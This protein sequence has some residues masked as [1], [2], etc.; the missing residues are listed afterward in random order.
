MDLI[1]IFSI[2]TI[3]LLVAFIWLI[4]V[5]RKSC[6]L[7][8]DNRSIEHNG[9]RRISFTGVTVDRYP[10]SSG[11]QQNSPQRPIWHSYSPQTQTSQS[12]QRANYNHSIET[13]RNQVNNIS[14]ANRAQNWSSINTTPPPKISSL[15]L[16]HLSPTL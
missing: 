3:V 16:I 4:C 12:N 15:L 13:F 9:S 5:C 14:Y 10:N 1:V 8:S 7:Y 6:R 11:H 2:V